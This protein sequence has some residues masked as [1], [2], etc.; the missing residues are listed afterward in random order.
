M[1]PSAADGKIWSVP[2]RPGMVRFV[3]LRVTSLNPFAAL[4]QFRKLPSLEDA[5]YE[6]EFCGDLDQPADPG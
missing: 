5:C 2:Q 4:I 3:V 6:L 1:R